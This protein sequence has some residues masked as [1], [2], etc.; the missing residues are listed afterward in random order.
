MC[1]ILKHDKVMTLKEYKLYEYT[2]DWILV[3]LFN[4]INEYS[5]AMNDIKNCI[6]KH[7]KIENGAL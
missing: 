6:E 5:K 7:V 1:N 4:D 3:T 2:D